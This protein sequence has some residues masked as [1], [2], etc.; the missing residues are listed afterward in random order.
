MLSGEGRRRHETVNTTYARRQRHLWAA[1][2][3]QIFGQ[4][5][6]DI[7]DRHGDCDRWTGT[8]HSTQWGM[9]TAHRLGRAG[10]GDREA[11]VLPPSFHTHTN[12]QTRTRTQC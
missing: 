8:E 10:A 11:P 1:V 5:R 2:V 3:T 9:M 6:Q 4:R 12:I 7:S